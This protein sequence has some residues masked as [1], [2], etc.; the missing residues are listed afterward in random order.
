MSGSNDPPYDMRAMLDALTAIDDGGVATNVGDEDIEM[1]DTWSEEENEKKDDEKKEDEKKDEKKNEVEVEK[2]VEREREEEK[3]VE[4]EGEEEK[5]EDEK[6]KEEEAER[7]NAAPSRFRTWRGLQ[8]V[9]TGPANPGPA[10]TQPRPSYQT[11]PPSHYPPYRPYRPHPAYQ[12]R[13]SPYQASPAAPPAVAVP[14]GRSRPQQ[15]QGAVLGKSKV[16][17]SERPKKEKRKKRL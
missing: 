17:K 12:P 2:E 15:P 6:E 9:P 11:R 5:K 3:E 8:N 14:S 7:I 4:K 10:P 16:Q 13:P 1:Q